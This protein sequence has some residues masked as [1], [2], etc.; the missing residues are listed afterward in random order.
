MKT[1]NVRM[2]GLKGPTSMQDVSVFMDILA[3]TVNMVI[4]KYNYNIAKITKTKYNT[5]CH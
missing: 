2:E 1:M 4:F 5:Y 3:N